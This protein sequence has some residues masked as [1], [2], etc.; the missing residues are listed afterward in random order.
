M[1]GNL[2]FERSATRVRRTWHPTLRPTCE[3]EMRGH[4]HGGSTSKSLRAIRTLAN[5]IASC[6]ATHVRGFGVPA[7]RLATHPAIGPRPY[8][9]RDQI[10]TNIKK[11]VPHT[12]PCELPARGRA[13]AAGGS[14]G[15][16]HPATLAGATHPASGCK[17]IRKAIHR[18]K[19]DADCNAIR[20]LPYSQ[21][22]S[23]GHSR[24]HSQGA[25]HV[26][27]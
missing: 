10:E 11:C 21:G 5:C 27:T 9:A 8:R 20:T 3:S 24:G 25:S 22:R 18:P 23:R 13:T 4:S 2:H 12:L 26:G 6:L 16:S 1:R 15:A 7:N 17:A 19:C 14:Q